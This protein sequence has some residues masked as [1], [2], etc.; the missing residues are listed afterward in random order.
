[1]VSM[2]SL[3]FGAL[4]QTAHAQMA[5]HNFHSQYNTRMST[6]TSTGTTHSI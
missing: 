2:T 1:M 5:S 3:A 4:E 6:T